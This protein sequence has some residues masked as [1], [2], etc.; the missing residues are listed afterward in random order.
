MDKKFI[1]SNA[2]SHLIKLKAKILDCKGKNITLDTGYLTSATY[3][4]KIICA[5]LCQQTEIADLEQRM[6]W[7]KEYSAAWGALCGVTPE[8]LNDDELTMLREHMAEF[9]KKLKRMRGDD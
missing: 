4:D 9:D 6:K 1:D 7:E 3:I 8:E 2:L 5:I